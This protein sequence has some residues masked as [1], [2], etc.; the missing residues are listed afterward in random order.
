[1]HGRPTWCGKEHTED[2]P[3]LGQPICGDCYDWSSHVVWQ[4]WA[5]EL[6]RRFTIALHRA[7]A[8]RLGLGEKELRDL[9]RVSFAKVAEFQR[10]GVV[11]F[12]AL[13]R[14]DGPKRLATTE[15]RFPA[16]LVDVDA[17]ELALLV[18][19]AATRVCFDA[20][21]THAGDV[22]RRLRFGG[23]VDARPVHAKADRDTGRQDT[24]G[25]LHPET[26][27][28]YIAKYATK[29]C[30]DFGLPARL[31]DPDAA[32]QLG[33][34]PHVCRIVAPCARGSPR[35]AS[36]CTRGRAGGCTCSASGVT[37]RPNPGRTPRRWAGCA[38]R[39]AAGGWRSCEP[40]AAATTTRSWWT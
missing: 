34:S 38:P 19:E 29:A 11:H 14:L 7:L 17:A 35:L 23:Q 10:R 31:R 6:W 16:P 21:P 20:P 26:V 3:V 12:H 9:V 28:A 39:G 8:A 1:M 27:A 40:P 30:E 2:D 24:S 32:V 25:E 4:W 18:R 33:L 15:G 13:I 5:P 37:S 36:P 22:V